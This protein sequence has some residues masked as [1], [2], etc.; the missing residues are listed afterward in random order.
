MR[1]IWFVLVTGNRWEAVP[2]ELGRSGRAAHR[3]LRT[4][5]KAG[6]WDRLHA[7]LLAALKREGK[8]D[9]DTVIIDGLTC[10]PLAVGRRLDQVLWTTADPA[11]NT[12]SWSTRRGF[13]LSSVAPARTSVTIASPSRRSSRFR[14]LAENLVVP[15]C[16]PTRSTLIA[17][18]IASP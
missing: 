14:K 13:G 10:E 18:M 8:L 16:Y 4:W 3:R 7:D 15:K 2:Q 11:Q 12:R 17:G 9:L 1:V 5:E 6:I